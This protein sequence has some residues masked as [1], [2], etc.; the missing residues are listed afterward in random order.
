MTEKR[1]YYFS[2]IEVVAHLFELYNN[3]SI[4]YNRNSSLDWWKR[5]KREGCLKYKET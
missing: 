1:P 3:Y 4:Y 2:L 5:G